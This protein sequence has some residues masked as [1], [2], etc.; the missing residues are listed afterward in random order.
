MHQ[1]LLHYNEQISNVDGS[2]LKEGDGVASTRQRDDDFVDAA[3]PS[4][5]SSRKTTCGDY[6]K[7]LDQLI[8]RPLLIHKYEKDRETRAREF[9]E[10]F[11][12]EGEQMKKLYKVEKQKTDANN[13][14]VSGRTESDN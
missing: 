6:F 12:E 5:K 10:M 3:D 2:G 11:Q 14:H 7:R 9:Y 4:K 13:S 1:P 8:L